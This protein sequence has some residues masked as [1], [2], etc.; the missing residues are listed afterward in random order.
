MSVQSTIRKLCERA[1]AERCCAT[2]NSRVLREAFITTQ[3]EAVV[4]KASVAGESLHQTY[5]DVPVWSKQI[6]P[7]P[8]EYQGESDD[9]HHS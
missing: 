1:L 6:S 5:P 4:H 2:P 3:L 7:A 8:P 9:Q